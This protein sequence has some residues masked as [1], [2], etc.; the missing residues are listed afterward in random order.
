MANCHSIADIIATLIGK[1][2]LEI[3]P[4]TLK[5]KVLDALSQYSSTAGFIIELNGITI[6]ADMLKSHPPVDQCLLILNIG[7][8]L[9]RVKEASNSEKELWNGAISKLKLDNK[10]SDAAKEIKNVFNNKV[11]QLSP[12]VK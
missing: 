2:L 4:D 12:E 6:L 8:K 5:L 1:T 7:K 11:T 10:C 9:F 3:P